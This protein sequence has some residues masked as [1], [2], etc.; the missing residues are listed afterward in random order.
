MGHTPGPFCWGGLEPKL[1]IFES[2]TLVKKRVQKCHF[3]GPGVA[4]QC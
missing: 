1:F 3:R 4:I 2:L